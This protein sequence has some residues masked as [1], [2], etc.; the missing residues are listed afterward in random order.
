VSDFIDNIEKGSAAAPGSVNTMTEAQ[1]AFQPQ[2]ILAPEEP[3]VYRSAD[4][5]GSALQRSAMFPT[6]RE[7]DYVSLLWSD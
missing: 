3:N 5:P 7:I 1:R 2:P 4:N 6:M